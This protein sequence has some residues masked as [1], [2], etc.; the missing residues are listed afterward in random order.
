MFVVYPFVFKKESPQGYFI[1]SI[2]IKEAYTG[3]NTEDILLVF[4]WQKKY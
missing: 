4:Q 3:I 1:E 2:D